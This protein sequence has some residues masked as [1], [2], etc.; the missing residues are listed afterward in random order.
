M[1]MSA[2]LHQKAWMI[3]QLTVAI[4]SQV[5]A[6]NVR[7]CCAVTKHAA[8]RLTS[9][10]LTN[11]CNRCR[12]NS[13]VSILS[14][15]YPAQNT[16]FYVQALQIRATESGLQVNCSWSCEL[17]ICATTSSETSLFHLLP[18]ILRVFLAYRF[19]LAMNCRRSDISWV[20]IFP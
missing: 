1:R 9:D 17:I 6:K 14:I 12:G 8:C 2:K 18:S 7:L 5:S 20:I 16:S 13:N 4:T 19:M 10:S 3:Q 11:R 15:P